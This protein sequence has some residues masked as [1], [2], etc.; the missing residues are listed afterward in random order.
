LWLLATK[1]FARLKALFRRRLRYF[2]AA[3][4]PEN[5][6]L[7]KRFL[8]SVSSKDSEMRTTFL[9]AAS[10]IWLFQAA[11]LHAATGVAEVQPHPRNDR[12]T[13]VSLT[14]PAARLLFERLGASLGLTTQVNGARF[15]S[16]QDGVSCYEDLATNPAEVFCSL[17]IDPAGNVT[18]APP[19]PAGIGVSN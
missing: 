10:A 1:A 18:G 5:A 17:A 14:G 7:L 4:A 6:T 13:A 9:V 8:R 3:G 12:Y 11:P 19:A 16:S 15:V 2:K